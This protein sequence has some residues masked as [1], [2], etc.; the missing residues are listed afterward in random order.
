MNKDKNRC[1][2]LSLFIVMLNLI[3][4]LL[5]LLSSNVVYYV[6]KPNTGHNYQIIYGGTPVTPNE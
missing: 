4:I 5:I 3:I 6:D 1:E 2:D